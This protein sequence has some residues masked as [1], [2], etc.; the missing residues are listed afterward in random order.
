MGIIPVEMIDKDHLIQLLDEY[1][2]FTINTDDNRFM[3]VDQG[4]LKQRL[5]ITIEHGDDFLKCAVS[6]NVH[7]LYRL[8]H[9]WSSGELRVFSPEEVSNAKA[10]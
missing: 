7:A 9:M 8:F 1:S 2:F 6:N 4:V 3:N 10:K 5:V